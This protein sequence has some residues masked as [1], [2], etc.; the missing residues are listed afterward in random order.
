MT[1][2]NDCH[3]EQDSIESASRLPAGIYK[4]GD[5]DRMAIPGDLHFNSH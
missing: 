2:V 5:V 1:Q 4:A 3:D